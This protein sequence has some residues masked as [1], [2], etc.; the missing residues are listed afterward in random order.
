MPL[1]QHFPPRGEPF[2]IMRSK[3]VDWLVN[4]AEVRQD[5]FNHFRRSG[6][7]IYDNGK[8]RGADTTSGG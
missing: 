1:L 6:A 7:I 3:V 2:D 4:Q 8:W 5:L